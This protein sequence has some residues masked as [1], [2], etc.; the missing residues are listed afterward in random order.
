MAKKIIG[1]V[2]TYRKG[3]II[4][5]AVSAV[6]E[7]AKQQGAETKKINLLERHIEFCTNCRQCTQNSGQAPGKCPIDD[8]MSEIL[9]EIESSDGYVLG[10]PI[11]FFTVTAL[12]KRFVERLIVYAYWPWGSKAPKM[13][14][15]QKNNKAVLITS[16]A[17]PAF[18][19]RILMHNAL[20]VLSS[21]ANCM[22]AKVIKRLYFGAIAI[23]KEQ[24]LKP[25]QL[26]KAREA[27]RKLAT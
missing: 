7:G 20:S 21:A 2:G 4:D 16:S 11:N 14:K 3:R 13:R 15:K 22:G 10:S 19:G 27:G 25:G 17:C 24:K 6:L 18:I 12:M 1:I 5:S 9:E 23:E 26:K 8:E